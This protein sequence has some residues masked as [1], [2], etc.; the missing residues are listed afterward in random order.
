MLFIAL[1]SVHMYDVISKLKTSCMKSETESTDSVGDTTM[2]VS[3]NASIDSLTEPHASNPAKTEPSSSNR[4]RRG[5]PVD[6]E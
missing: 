6:V 2:P 5:F 1:K 3:E 4:S